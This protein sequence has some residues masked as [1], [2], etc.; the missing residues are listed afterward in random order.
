MKRTEFILAWLLLLSFAP[1]DSFGQSSIGQSL[2]SHAPPA[3]A[4]GA[5]RLLVEQVEELSKAGQLPEA[6]STLEKLFEQS[7]GRLIE[8][9]GLQ[10]AS[11]QV[12]QRYVSLRQWTQMRLSNL[13]IENASIRQGYLK[14]HDD[15]AAAALAE[16]AAS[17]D[18]VRA[19]QAAE[20]FSQTTS[21]SKLQLL[22]ADLY[23]ERGW[24]LAATQT[25]QKQLPCMRFSF[26]NHKPDANAAAPNGTLAWP[27]VIEHWN[28]E[29]RRR[30]MREWYDRLLVESWQ[31]SAPPK[32][33]VEIL[34]AFDRCRSNW[35][36]GGSS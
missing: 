18:L 8:A 26:N 15:A 25:L 29:E 34:K 36:V 13:L 6:A 16:V 24:G 5:E 10:R 1:L 30:G 14:D 2:G 3:I 12:M 11:T 27:Q 4:T 21:G 22:L 19:R 31:T 7:E 9:E 33:A 35:H 20:R 32:L 23:L 17:K 28:E